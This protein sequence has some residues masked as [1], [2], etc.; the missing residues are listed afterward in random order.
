MNLG[1]PTLPRTTLTPLALDPALEGP[2][3]DGMFGLGDII[4]SHAEAS[5]AG[6]NE[7]AEVSD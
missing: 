6:L 1:Q 4:H 7:L 5:S 3:V 2:S